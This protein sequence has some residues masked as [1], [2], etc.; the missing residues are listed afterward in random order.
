[1]LRNYLKIAA[2]HLWHQK[3]YTALNV[4]G[5]AVGMATCLLI[6]LYIQ[7]ELS[8]DDFHPQADQIQLM[9][10]GDSSAQGATAPYP[11]GR[12][13]ANEVPGVER[14]TR[15]YHDVQE[16]PVRYEVDGRRLERSLQVLKA[17]SSFFRVLTGFP[18]RRGTRTGVLDAPNEA[19]ITESMAQA[20]FGEKD[21]IGQTLT[22]EGDS[23]RRYAVVGVTT[24][25]SNSTVQFDMVVAWNSVSPSRRTSWSG[26]VTRTYAQVEEG[27]SSRELGETATQTSPLERINDDYFVSAMSLPDFYLSDEYRTGSFRG[28]VRYLY[29]FGTVAL[30]VLLIA[31]VN[32]VNL[33]TAQAQ[34]RAREV[35]VRKAMGALRGQVARQFLT[36]TLL[37]SGLA[38]VVAIAL[39]SGSIPAFNALFDKSLSLA[40][41]RHGWAL[42]G[43]AGVVL[44]VTL[45]GGAYPA[46]ILSGFRPTRILRSASSTMTSSGGWL[47]KGLVV[48]QFAV[49]AGLILGTTVIYQ[50]LDYV[51]TKDLG[52]D[53]EQVVTVDL[54]DLDER[55]RQLVRR[56]ARRNP[57]VRA[58]SVGS[59]APGGR[60][61]MV[62]PRTPAELSPQAQVS[63]ED[64]ILLRP[65][66]V[67]TNY[68]ETLGLNVLAG[69]SFAT[70]VPI[71]GGR[72]YILNQAAVAAMGWSV[73][74]AV[75]KPFRLTQDSEQPRGTVIGVVENFHMASLHSPIAP[76]VLALQL[77]V[78]LSVSMLAARLAPDG[79]PA[80][81]DHL[82]EVMSGA[83][84]QAEFSYTFLDDK[85][86]AMYRSERRLARIFATFAI[87]AII[88]ACMGLF[89]LA[90]F[91]AQR[92]TREIGIR[93][94]L[95]ASMAHIV[96]LLS[97]EYAALVAG[98][99][100]VGLPA[101]Y[102]WVQRWLEDFAYRVDIGIG[103]FAFAAGLVLGVAGI[104]VSYHALRAARTDPAQTLRDE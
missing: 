52:F 83:A 101:A 12:V 50:Q 67:D 41:A 104:T 45:L 65:I 2:R 100:V 55:Q 94:A 17:D 84:P 34:Q 44:T 63:S 25:P 58:A 66:Q 81:V 30:L 16:R 87:I 40:R 53:D 49:S 29:I 10:V 70:S 71:E 75:G 6:G 73:E 88:V 76:V 92:R 15:T 77:D 98:A 19:V 59:L 48:A 64:N 95:G 46:L 23:V 43:G 22:V 99:L 102:L 35:G 47:R 38:L 36:E 68:V 80:G 11:L 78:S 39:V 72:R 57:N 13:L 60:S 90:A 54:D 24:V 61:R 51:Q 42:A 1:M 3:G 82:R 31:M 69:Q 93:M 9:M 56:R 62:F 4:G 20:F 97:K 33:V 28:Q 96:G 37:L 32:Y 5:L 27:L 26:F 21:P 91:A 18:L 85:F 7:D 79:I 103:T 8:Y 74:E 14:V 89:G 86:D